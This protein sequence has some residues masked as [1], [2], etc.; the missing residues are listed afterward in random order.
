MH[1]S[2]DVLPGAQR[3]YALQD[4]THRPKAAGNLPVFS[5]DRGLQ[6]A[7]PKLQIFRWY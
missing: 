7:W 3:A 2:A 5:Q 1:V 6:V 4:S